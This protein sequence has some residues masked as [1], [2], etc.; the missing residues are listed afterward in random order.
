M[1]VHGEIQNGHREESENKATADRGRTENFLE[2]FLSEKSKG[3]KV[4]FNSRH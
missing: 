3:F 2:L 4:A 1:F